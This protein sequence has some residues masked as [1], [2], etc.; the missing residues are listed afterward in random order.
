VSCRLHRPTAAPSPLSPGA[1]CPHVSPPLPR[2]VDPGERNNIAATN[3]AKV[4]ELLAAM[5]VRVLSSFIR[6]PHQPSR[7]RGMGEGD[8]RYSCAETTLP[9]LLLSSIFY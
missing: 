6:A 7:E 3:P 8:S 1:L 2:K 9:D 4:A 5:K